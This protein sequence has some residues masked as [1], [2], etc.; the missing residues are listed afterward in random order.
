MDFDGS[1]E[2]LVLTVLFMSH[3]QCQNTHWPSLWNSASHF[4][5]TARGILAFVFVLFGWSTA[6]SYMPQSLSF[7]CKRWKGALLPQRTPRWRRR[8]HEGG[9][10]S[11]VVLC[12]SLVKATRGGPTHLPSSVKLNEAVVISLS[13][14]L[15]VARSCPRRRVVPQKQHSRDWISIKVEREKIF[16]IFDANPAFAFSATAHGWRPWQWP[17]AEAKFCRGCSGELGASGNYKY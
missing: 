3:F 5:K 2:V 11:G 13:H 16:L 15:F 14:C 9:G 4:W 10:S 6:H 12:S 17:R 1:L 8:R 7:S